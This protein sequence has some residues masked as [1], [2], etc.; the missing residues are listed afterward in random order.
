MPFR[1]GLTGGVAS[2][3]S[4]AA[5]RFTEL[6]VEVVDADR[7]ARELVAPGTPLLERIRRIFGPEFIDGSGQ[8]DRRRLRERVFADE[9]ARRTLEALL[10]PAIRDAMERR[11]EAAASPYVVLMIPLLVEKG[12]KSL[13]DRVLVVD[14]PEEEQIRRLCARDA[15]DPAL[16][17][18]MVA[19]QASRRERLAAA[20]DVLLNTGDREA[21]RR[22]VDRLHEDYLKQ[23]AAAR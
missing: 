11:A 3:K 14:L 12:L 17:R 2:G 4:T 10:H 5:E 15:I 20:D 1:V 18:R 19:S 9:A 16:A 7:I 21:L 23:A 13:V 6:G 8:L 22:A